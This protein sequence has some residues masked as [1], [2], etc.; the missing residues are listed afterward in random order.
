MQRCAAAGRHDGRAPRTA[1]P[2]PAQVRGDAPGKKKKPG[3][4]SLGARV[5]CP[6]ARRR[7]RK[8]RALSTHTP[9]G[10]T[11]GSKKI[12]PF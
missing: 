1:K 10:S 9:G 3:A 2:P 7:S 11:R 12:P 5:M 6:G 4:K 8:L